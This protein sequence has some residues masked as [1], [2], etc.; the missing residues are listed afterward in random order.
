MDYCTQQM[1]VV[2]ASHHRGME[3]EHASFW[4]GDLVVIC[5]SKVDKVKRLNLEV[6]F[7]DRVNLECISHS[8]NGQF[9]ALPLHDQHLLIVFE[10]IDLTGE[11]VLGKY[12]IEAF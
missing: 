6:S 1:G 2:G 9:T 11:T 10:K 5:I 8:L 4:L 3:I 7:T 12:S